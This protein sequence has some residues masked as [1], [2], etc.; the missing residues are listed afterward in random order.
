VPVVTIE[1][2]H[3]QDMPKDAELDR[4]WQDM[5]NWVGRSVGGQ[6]LADARS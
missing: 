2:P 1:L 5:L 4:T 3:A 6:K